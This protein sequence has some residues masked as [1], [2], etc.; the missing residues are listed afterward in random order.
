MFYI[1]NIVYHQSIE[2]F[3]YHIDF[4]N[5]N[6]H[7]NFQCRHP[8]NFQQKN[9]YE[10]KSHSSRKLLVARVHCK[11]NCDLWNHIFANYSCL[12][13]DKILVSY[14]V[15]WRRNSLVS[16]RSRAMVLNLRNGPSKVNQDHLAVHQGH[17]NFFC[18]FLS[19]NWV[20]LNLFG[21]YRNFVGWNFAFFLDFSKWL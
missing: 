21:C 13:N 1:A 3:A 17:F 11:Q 5:W 2:N 4:I 10:R 19:F 9:D 12:C 14:F 15:I 20:T 6:D 8:K 18:L 7:H 16:I